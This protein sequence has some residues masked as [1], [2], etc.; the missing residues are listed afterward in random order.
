MTAI[1][2]TLSDHICLIM[3]SHFDSVFYSSHRGTACPVSFDSL[4]NPIKQVVQVPTI[5]AACR[6]SERRC[7]RPLY[8]SAHSASMYGSASLPQ[9]LSGGGSEGLRRK[10]VEEKGEKA[11]MSQIGCVCI[12]MM[13]ENY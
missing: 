2:K 13:L 7:H 10:N 6:S 1:C 9:A 3:H 11:K 12:A 4:N 8:L 5:Q